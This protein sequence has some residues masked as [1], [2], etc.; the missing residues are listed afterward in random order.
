MLSVIFVFLVLSLQAFASLLIM[1]LINWGYALANISLALIVYIYIGQA[2]PG[3]SKG[4]LYDLISRRNRKNSLRLF[5]R[6]IAKCH[7]INDLVGLKD[8]I[9]QNKSS[10]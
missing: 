2:N 3:L 10:S 9:E 1:F 8:S 4:K 6:Y 5:P 7:Q